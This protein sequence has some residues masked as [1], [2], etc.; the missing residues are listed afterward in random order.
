[1]INKKVWKSVQ[2]PRC[3]VV[4]CALCSGVRS[5]LSA[6][7]K[8]PRKK[9]LMLRVSLK[10]LKNWR[11]GTQITPPTF[12]SIAHLTFG[13]IQPLNSAAETE[14]SFLAK[15]FRLWYTSALQVF[16]RNSSF[17]IQC[18][19][20]AAKKFA[21]NYK[22]WNWSFQRWTKPLLKLLRSLKYIF[23]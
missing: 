20:F 15:N 4:K 23:F 21:D 18:A 13:H 9:K 6:R 17:F 7:F 12:L 1:M 10:L 2:S 22:A 14:L 5:D 16:W 3:A 8:R 19:T 11:N